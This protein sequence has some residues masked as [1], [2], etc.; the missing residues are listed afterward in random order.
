MTSKET[1]IDEALS[2]LFD[3]GMPRA[4]LNDR[5]A[6]CLLALLDLPP[7]QGWA[8]CSAHLKGITPIMEWARDHF[9]TDYKPNTRETF[10]RQSMHQFMEARICLLQPGRSSASG[11]QPKGG[12]SN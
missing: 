2:V 3:L 12:L 10:R 11:E 5:T 9:D 6:L 4:Q 7:S 8:T 1:R